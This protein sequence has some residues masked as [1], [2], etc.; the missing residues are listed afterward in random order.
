MKTI[1]PLFF[2]LFFISIL[3][4]QTPQWITYTSSNSGL[5]GNNTKSIAID[6]SG[7][8]W[9]GTQQGLAKFDG[10]TWKVYSGNVYITPTLYFI[11]TDVHDITIDNNGNKWM[12]V[13]GLLAKFDGTNWK[14]YS[15]SN[16]GMPNNGVLSIVED[17]SGNIWIGTDGGGIVKFDGTNFTIYNSSNSGLPN[18]TIFSL[19]IDASGNKWVTTFGGG[20]AK[21]DGTTWTVYNTSNSGI[22]SNSLFNA[23]AIDGSGNKWLSTYDGA[24]VKFDGTNWT[25]YN[26]S[27]SLIPAYKK[28]FSLAIDGSDN[29]WIGM[30][31][32]ELI[33]FDGTNWTVYT[34]PDPA[35]SSNIIQ[36][37]AIDGSGNKWLGTYG[38]GVSVFK[39][40]GVTMPAEQAL[41]GEF[42]YGIQNWNLSTYATGATATIQVDSSSA[43]SGKNSAA[44]TISQ[45]TGTDWHIQMWQWL[46]LKQGHKYTITFKA[47]ASAARSII[48][49]VQKGASPYTT[50]LFNAHN[51]T[52]QVQTFTDEVTMNTTDLAAKLQFY[53]GSSSAKVW[54]DDITS[55]DNNLTTD[56]DEPVDANRIISVL[57]N[58]PNPFNSVTTIK[59][60][61]TQPGFVLL[62][63]F[64]VLGTEVASLVNE[65]K[66]VGDYSIDWNAAGS[67]NGIYFC[68]MQN[69]S[70]TEVKKMMLM[71]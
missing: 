7:T 20:L 24:L 45:T 8:K 22:P 35:L 21:F 40:G 47:K 57:Q 52:T 61:V 16:T 13:G 59:Y 53:L 36:A 37:I 44:I 30:E 10:T 58:Y 64:D 43:I 62:K 50:Y 66:A 46:S 26:S 19:A 48:L 28:I 34:N 5:P 15:S 63:V 31:S 11:L 49:A 2:S 41:N 69:G 67:E 17:G 56:L 60:K 14:V 12:S 39:E 32:G 65:K 71:K 4:A 51:L 18:N 23:I 1:L 27:N 25:V 68:K 29:K 6:A 38:G 33:K 42:N 9:I 3:S 55:V 70:F 54:I